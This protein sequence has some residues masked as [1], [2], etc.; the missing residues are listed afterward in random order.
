[1]VEQVE[2]PPDEPFVPG[3]PKPAG[4]W[5]E[6]DHGRLMCDVCP[7][8]CVLGPDDRG[9]CFVREN[10]EGR[11]V[12]TTYGRSTGFCI[13]P[14]EKK[15]LA[16]FYPG[17]AVLSFGT[18]GCNLG[19][20]FCQNWTSTKSREVDRFCDEAAP[21]AVAEA[22]QKLGC[23]SVAYTYNDPIVWVEYA[24]DTARAA[25]ALGLKNVAVTSGYML[26]KPRAAFY[27]WMD[28]ANIDLKAFD[29]SF[30]RRL[31]AGRLEPV[32]DTLR[33]LVHETD[34]WLEITNLV[35]PRENDSPDDLKR[36]SAWIVETLG[37]DIPVHFSAFHPDFRM[38][39]YPRTPMETLIRAYEIAQ[40]AG[41]KYVYT[42]NVSDVER[43][44]TY[45]PHCG[46]VLIE[47][48]GYELSR[49]AL[50]GDRCGHCGTAVAG[51]Y[52]AAPGNWGSR[53]Q[54]VRIAD[55]A[56]AK[57]TEE[58]PMVSQRPTEIDTTP[59]SADRPMLDDQQEAAVFGMAGA[60]VAAT[61]RGEPIAK[62]E[63]LDPA[64]GAQ[65]ML[66]AFVSLKRAGQLRSCCGF[67]GQSVPLAEAIR[68][69]AVRAARDDPRFPPIS[70]TELD[71]LDMEV[72]LL[73]GLEPVE[74]KGQDRV[75]AVEIGRHGL[76]IQR[77]AA[78]GLLLPAV[79]TEHGLDA[80][81]FLRQ[82]CLKAQL[83]PDA[84]KD[85]S[86]QL[87]TF[88]G[89]AIHGALKSVIDP[90]E[91][92]T[93]P[94]GPSPEQLAALAKYC[95]ENLIA[96]FEGATPSYY[97]PGGFDGSVHGLLLDVRPAGAAQTISVHR[98]SVKPPL[99]L[100]STLFSLLQALA[101][102]LRGQRLD[103]GMLANAQVNLSV[104]WDP[105]LHG[106][107]DKPD[108]AGV[109]PEKRAIL[110]LTR[111][112][113]ASVYDVKQSAEAAMAEAI[114]LAHLPKG[115]PGSVLSMAIAS[116]GDARVIA[117]NV[118]SPEAPRP[119]AVAGMFYPGNVREMDAMLDTMLPKERKTEAWAG[120]MVPHAGWIYSGKLAA[121]VLSRIDI[122]SR[123]IIF[124]PKHNAVGARWAVAPHGRW[125]LPG[126]VVESDRELAEQ[127]AGAV[128]GLELDGAAHRPEHAVEV[129]LPI[130]A[131]LAPETHVVGVA[132]HGGE[133]AELERFA[134][135]LAAMI[136]GLVERPLLIVSTDMNHYA[137]EAE[138]ERLDRMALAAIEARDPRRLLEVVRDNRIT[139]CGVVPAVVVM[140]T[141]RRLGS[142]DEC[143]LVGHTTS[144][145]QTHD[146]TR[147]VG[148]AGAL[149]R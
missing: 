82:V 27:E 125:V 10:R 5:H 132:M 63:S 36:M 42:G 123:A 17:T 131:R 71:H 130:L 93:A 127:L 148:Y 134:E 129:Q 66:G 122:P 48:D 126:R 87:M 95:R 13:D 81:G 23:R 3:E 4:W 97:L 54:P 34:V 25:R 105:A 89:Y 91:Q 98:L 102:G 120:A 12:S 107:T 90:S 145:G 59:S 24:I 88:E 20:R 26:P 65:P 109:D 45:C 86:T 146:K 114:R 68:H 124:C 149:F 55:F 35:I 76:Q 31:C 143:Q 51:R 84:W 77:G 128:D 61:V 115:T 52:D 6:V 7:R 92:E 15:P 116:S 137:D 74:A 99:P 117:T 64:L 85:D 138:T 108:L 53:R 1:M 29:E 119:A 21:E 70:P 80:E 100:Q 73:W 67:L 18:A 69:A 44:T 110:V 57:K 22:A 50:K 133:W 32:L 113:W 142:L 112:G 40:D 78:R 49:Y 37:A 9:F 8:A 28:A 46:G 104:L 19:C 118:P 141:L 144:A 121:D 106:S 140:E 79:A 11:I 47:R 33:W 41:L 147:V 72:W 56:Q 83:P 58:E 14:I 136:D 103:A 43:A 16:Q 111:S 38:T 94:G 135:Q 101:G 75:G 39:D 62:R 96:M 139:M 60:I 2:R 30:Y